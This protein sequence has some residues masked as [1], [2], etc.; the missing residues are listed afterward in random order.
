MVVDGL[1]DYFRSC[2]DMDVVTTTFDIN[3]IIKL[4]N[5]HSPDILLMDY[6]FVHEKLTGLDVCRQI[7]SDRPDTRVVIISSFSDVALIKEFMD[8]GARGYLLKT[9]TRSEFI[10]AIYNVYA[11]G[12]WYGKDV[13]ELLVKEKLRNSGNENVRFTKIEKEI[14]K[15][16][17]EG[18]STRDIARK[19]F[20]EKSTIDSHRKSI[21][22]K[23]QIKDGRKPNPS[24]NILYFV[25]R[26]NIS[27][28][29]ENL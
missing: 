28:N 26:F 6:H 17:I 23:F 15:L 2:Q 16:I 29:L 12:E 4:V 24:K 7:V 3:S 14:L 22:Y 20:R 8:A 27:V 10:D 25:T 1:V 9:A 5:Q 21:L 13:R 11:G 19:L 18:N